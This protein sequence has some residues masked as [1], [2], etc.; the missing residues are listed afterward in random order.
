MLFTIQQNEKEIISVNVTLE[1]FLP[2]YQEIVRRFMELSKI[3]TE[4]EK[5]EFLKEN[6]VCDIDLIFESKTMSM[7]TF[8]DFINFIT[9]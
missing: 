9:D 2:Y 5:Q 1:K 4:E 3:K 6:Y 7:N 8:Q